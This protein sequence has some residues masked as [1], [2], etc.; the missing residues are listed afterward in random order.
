MAHPISLSP[1]PPPPTRPLD[2]RAV[3]PPSNRQ[4]QSFQQ[5][6]TQARESAITMV[7]AEGDV[8]S[9]SGGQALYQATAAIAASTGAGGTALSARHTSLALETMSWSVQGDLNDEEL[10]D[11][12]NLFTDLQ[13]IA[14]DF[15]NG[16]LQAAATGALN[17]GDM[18]SISALSASFSFR[19]TVATSLQQATLPAAGQLEG[20]ADNFSDPSRLRKEGEANRYTEMIKAQWRQINGAL[21]EALTDP[22]RSPEAPPPPPAAPQESQP[23][24][25]ERMLQRLRRTVAS[26]PRLAP[27]AMPLADN[28]IDRTLAENHTLENRHRAGQ[29][30]DELQNR[31]QHWLLSA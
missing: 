19:A 8:V 24:A 6:A 22:D 2:P 27:L 9:L 16:D 17:L 20:M 31:F 18:G 11:I 10:A 13:T 28:A 15:F 3:T 23:S 5:V 12:K 7:T 4:N 1:L 26:H 14:A 21:L 29:L 25:G 30:K